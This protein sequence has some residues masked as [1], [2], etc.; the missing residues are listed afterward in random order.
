MAAG[1]PATAMV[2]L[3]ARRALECG[4]TDFTALS[5]ADNRPVAE[6]AHEGQARW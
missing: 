3:R 5:L 4:I 2:E 1:R 6:L